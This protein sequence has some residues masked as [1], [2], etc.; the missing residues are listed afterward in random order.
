MLSPCRNPVNW[1]ATNCL[2]LSVWTVSGTPNAE[3]TSSCRNR[4]TAAAVAFGIARNHTNLDRWSRTT[5]MVVFPLLDLGYGPRKS[6]YSLCIGRSDTVSAPITGLANC[7]LC[8]VALHVS[9]PAT[10]LLTCATIP[11]QKKNCLSRSMVLFMPPCIA[12]SLSWACCIRA[13][14]TGRGTQSFQENSSRSGRVNCARLYN[15]PSSTRKSGNSSAFSRTCFS[16]SVYSAPSN[17]VVSKSKKSTSSSSKGRE[18]G[19]RPPR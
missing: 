13:A 5:R 15:S 17:S 10:Y 4:T 12:A 9:Q 16:R 7:V 8:F 18:R 1:L 3:N 11:G 14:D 19:Q 6:R 2:P